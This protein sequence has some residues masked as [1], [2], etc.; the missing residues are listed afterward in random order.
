MKIYLFCAYG[1][2]TD[3]IVGKVKKVLGPD[4]EIHAFGIT[5]LDSKIPECD[6]AMLA[7]QA[8]MYLGDAKKIGQAN[9]VPVDA[10]EMVA[11][12]R[13]DAQMIYN[14]AKKLYMSK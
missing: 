7:P 6:V 9:G 5:E 8:R 11:F 13:Q 1:M 2:T 14:Q 4:D 10:I 3:V 12:G